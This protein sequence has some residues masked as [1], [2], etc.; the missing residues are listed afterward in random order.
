MSPGIDTPSLESVAAQDTDDRFEA[1]SGTIEVVS[2]DPLFGNMDGLA[3]EPN[4]SD[5][6]GGLDSVRAVLSDRLRLLGYPSVRLRKGLAAFHEE[7]A[8]LLSGSAAVQGRARRLSPGT[9]T[10]QLLQDLLAFEGSVRMDDWFVS[11]QPRLPL[12]RAIRARLRALGMME[13][14]RPLRQLESADW[15]IISDHLVSFGKEVAEPL[16]LIAEDASVDLAKA[17]FDYEAM[18]EAIA[19]LDRNQL[20]A[21]PQEFVASTAMIELWLL[22]YDVRP[23]SGQKKRRQKAKEADQLA[24]AINSFWGDFD[25]TSRDVVHSTRESAVDRDLFAAFAAVRNGSEASSVAEIAAGVSS[26]LDAAGVYS[27]DA[28]VA[29]SQFASSKW[30]G[31]GHARR[32]FSALRSGQDSTPEGARVRLKNAIRLAT[33][34]ARDAFSGVK[35]SVDTIRAIR[36]RTFPL[37]EESG[38]LIQRDGNFD[39][40]VAIVEGADIQ[41]A[42]DAVERFTQAARLFRI[43]VDIVADLIGSIRRLSRKALRFGPIGLVLAIVRMLSEDKP[44]RRLVA[45]GRM[46]G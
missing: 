38:V 22:G 37:S 40:L 5:D 45:M 2:S 12:Q 35:V 32:W 18:L 44:A 10:W 9:R 31:L 20:A 11:G 33:A 26:E 24:A 46:A 15:Q 28:S 6:E 25:Q 19:G 34:I 3:E 21:L 23:S 4:A 27:G 7:C 43:A 1:L 36:S 17:L 39:Y 30:D 16:G 14:P 13:E 29:F 8:E 41:V 42:T